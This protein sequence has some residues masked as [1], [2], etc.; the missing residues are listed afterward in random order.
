MKIKGAKQAQKTVT[1]ELMGGQVKLKPVSMFFAMEIEDELPEPKPKILDY[2][3]N[4]KGQIIRDERGV[5]VP[6]YDTEDAEYRKAV[7]K[8]QILQTVKMIVDSV[9][10][11]IEFEADPDL[12]KK[13]FDKYYSGI[14]G[15]MEEAGLT[16]GDIQ[17][18]G[19][20]IQKISGIDSENSQG[21]KQNFTMR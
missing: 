8:N 19:K 7:K 1:V 11:G 12:R 4:G 2:A 5:A 15:E 9:V 16:I 17:R 21:V 10:D 20:E 18:L 3:R 14:L 6:V 13:D